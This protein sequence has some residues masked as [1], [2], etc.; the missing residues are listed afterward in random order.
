MVI[1]TTYYHIFNFSAEREHGADARLVQIS[2]FKP[3]SPGQQ[4]RAIRAAKRRGNQRVNAKPTMDIDQML[5]D[6]EHGA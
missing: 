6:L 1:K 5:E 3:N 4:A 2:E